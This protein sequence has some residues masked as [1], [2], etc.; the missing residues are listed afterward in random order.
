M[1]ADQLFDAL[2]RS[3]KPITPARLAKARARADSPD[4]WA[5]VQTRLAARVVSETKEP[6]THEHP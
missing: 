1:T 3:G 4:V 5:E 6:T 2:T